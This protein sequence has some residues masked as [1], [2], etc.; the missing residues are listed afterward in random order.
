MVLFWTTRVEPRILR[1][2]QPYIICEAAGGFLIKK[3][4][5]DVQFA[6][7]QICFA[8][9]NAHKNVTSTFLILKV[10]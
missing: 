1:P 10:E 5:D 4:P 7:R 8:S 2:L 3:P 9:A 6:V